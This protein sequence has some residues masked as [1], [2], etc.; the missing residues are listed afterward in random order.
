MSSLLAIFSVSNQNRRSSLD[1]VALVSSEEFV[2][3]APAELKAEAKEDPHQFHLNRLSFEI[4][5]RKRFVL[6]NRLLAAAH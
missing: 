4:Q 2:R 3:A 5:E 6:S 1:S